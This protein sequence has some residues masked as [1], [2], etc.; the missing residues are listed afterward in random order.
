MQRFH[1]DI[2]EEEIHK[3]HRFLLPSVNDICED[4]FEVYALIPA[5]MGL[6]KVGPYFKAQIRDLHKQFFPKS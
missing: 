4:C 3:R 5:L 6:E 1:C 2:C